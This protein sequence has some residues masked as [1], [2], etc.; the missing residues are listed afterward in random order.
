[1]LTF[2][3]LLLRNSSRVSPEIQTHQ[4]FYTILEDRSWSPMVRESFLKAVLC[5]INFFSVYTIYLFSCY[6]L[7]FR[8]YVYCNIEKSLMQKANKLQAFMLLYSSYLRFN[9]KNN[10]FLINLLFLYIFNYCISLRK[11]WNLRYL[12]FKCIFA[13][14]FML[15]D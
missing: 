8:M 3:Q 5:I 12:L 7:K 15:T 4:A 6:Y 1:M 10:F 13:L 14:N 9:V 2:F 11:F